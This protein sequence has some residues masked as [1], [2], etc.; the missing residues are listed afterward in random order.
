MK[1]TRINDKYELWL[2][3]HRADRPEWK[4]ENGGWEVK[5]IEAM[6]ERIGPLDTVFDLGTEEG[7][8]SAIIAAYRACDII[9]FE[10][11]DRVWSCIKAIWNANKIKRPLDF[12]AGFISDKNK[13]GYSISWDDIQPDN[14][15]SDHGFK[16][17][18]ENYPDVPQCTLDEY[19]RTTGYIPTVI[20]M[21][22]E[23]AEFQVIKGATEVLSKH[24]PTIFMSIH[25]DFM[26]ESYKHEGH[27]KEK[28]GDERQRV[29]HLL[30][31]IDELGYTHEIL[32]WDY[33]EC[34]AIFSPA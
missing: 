16:Q 33:H 21:D 15:V 25:P 19:C 5:R 1:L 13:P 7:D 9:L 20:T 8:I 14:L 31:T 22:V 18:Y 10:P 23:G 24:K 11:N 17:L 27:W 2:P 12:Y 4:L 26:F 28:F 29:V 6:M 30:R 34:H 3:D 32:E